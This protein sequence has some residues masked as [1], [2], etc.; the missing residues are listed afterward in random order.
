[1]STTQKFHLHDVYWQM[2]PPTVGAI[3]G[4]RKLAAEKRARGTD[5]L[6]WGQM[7]VIDP[8]EFVTVGDP[9]K[10]EKKRKT[11]INATLGARAQPIWNKTKSPNT[12][13]KIVLRPLH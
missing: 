12:N 3:T 6:S 8:P 10:P 9:K 4:P 2:K 1:M 11:I 7:S 5:R 13:R